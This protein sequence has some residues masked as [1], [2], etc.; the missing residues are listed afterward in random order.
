MG[1]QHL[2]H[3]RCVSFFLQ[4]PNTTAQPD[5]IFGKPVTLAVWKKSLQTKF[6]L[7]QCPACTGRY[8]I[9]GVT[10]PI[11]L[12]I[13]TTLNILIANRYLACNTCKTDLY[14]KIITHTTCTISVTPTRGEFHVYNVELDVYHN[15]GWYWHFCITIIHICTDINPYKRVCSTISDKDLVLWIGFIQIVILVEEVLVPQKSSKLFF[16]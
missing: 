10:T 6:G 7:C 12:H 11:F 14:Y 8:R 9:A 1:H 3:G 4:T 15:F 2:K 13:K 16:L 5:Y